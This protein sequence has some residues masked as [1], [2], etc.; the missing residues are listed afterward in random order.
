MN[1]IRTFQEKILA[2]YELN[3]RDLPWRKTEDPYEILV[4]E[5]M[6]QQTQVPR[7]IIKFQT[8]LQA[9]PTAAALADASRASVIKAWAGLGYN[10][11]ALYLH[12]CAKQIVTKFDGVLPRDPEQL[13][14]LPG[15][16]PYMCRSVL[17]FAFNQDVAAV[18]TNIR[19]ILI[20]EGFATQKTSPKDMQKIAERVLPHGRSRDW[21]NA[22]MD[23]GSLVLTSQGTGIKPLS[24][25]SSFYK[26]FRWYRSKVVKLIIKEEE[27]TVAR[28]ARELEKE[29]EFVAQVIE[30]LRKDNLISLRGKKITLPK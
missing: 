18:D 12:E 16:G 14:E 3:R 23:Y 6:L 20:A 7:V 19:R 28:I 17:I 13:M 29:K 9:F 22:L 30:S 26:S 5:L 8:F 4:S 24:K 21:H 25:Q 11:R 10:R 27:V 15:I 1:K 2:W